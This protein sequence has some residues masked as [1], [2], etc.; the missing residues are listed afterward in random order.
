MPIRP[1]WSKLDDERL[2]EAMD[3]DLLQRA[4]DIAVEQG[5]DPEKDP[6]PKTEPVHVKSE[7]IE[8]LD[9]ELEAEEI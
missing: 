7:A 3:L 6:G 5:R 8:L 1:Q 9:R 4:K 2:R